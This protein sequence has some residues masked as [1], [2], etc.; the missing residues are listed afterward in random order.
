MKLQF[1]FNDVLYCSIIYYLYVYIRYGIIYCFQC[2]DIGKEFCFL[3]LL[4]NFF[5]YCS[6]VCK[7]IYGFIRKYGLNMC[8]RCFREYVDDI[9]FKKVLELF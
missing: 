9:G 8:R 2:S 7:N 4:Y 3:D 1:D 6:R 5:F